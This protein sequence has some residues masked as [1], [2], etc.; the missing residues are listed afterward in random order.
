MPKSYR[1]A[2]SND[3][4]PTITEMYD[5]VHSFTLDC[6]FDLVPNMEICP[7]SLNENG[8][9]VE[10]SET[11]HKWAPQLSSEDY[12]KP[13]IMCEECGAIKTK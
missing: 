1:V 3:T 6:A 10:Y 5:C 2:E 4:M 12:S 11:A 8:L 13:T 7:S 9:P